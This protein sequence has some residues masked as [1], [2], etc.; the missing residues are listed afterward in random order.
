[1]DPLGLE[2]G[3]RGQPPQDQKRAGTGQRPSLGVEEE[4]RT[5]SAVEVWPTSGQ[6]APQG[7][8]GLAAD[9]HDP[10]F[11]ALAD[12][13][14]EPLVEVDAGPVERDRLADSK[15]GA[16]EQLDE[17]AIPERSGR[18]PRSRVDQAVRFAGGEGARQLADPAWK[19][20]LGRRVPGDRADQDQMAEQG[21]E[22]GDAAGDRRRRE[23]CGSE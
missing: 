20:E 14:D 16:V 12:R 19:L 8:D 5:V 2:P 17:R 11:S 23:T 18:R 15:P 7:L 1:M 9:R 4:L 6:V 22:R 21:A 10:L 13:P 3:L